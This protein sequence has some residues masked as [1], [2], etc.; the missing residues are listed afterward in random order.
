MVHVR[1]EFFDLA[2]G[3][4]AP[5]AE[6]ALRRIAALYAVET[7]VRGKPPDLRRAAR[8][9]RSRALVEDL[10]T[11]FEAQLLRLPGRAPTAKAIRYALNHRAGLE[12]LLDDGRIEADQV[13][14][15]TGPFHRPLVPPIAGQ[16]APEV[17]QA[18][19][20]GYRTPSDVP[21]G[22]VLVVL[23]PDEVPA[24]KSFRNLEGVAVMAAENAGVADIVGA[25]TLVASQA[26]VDALTARARPSKRQEASA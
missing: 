3:G 13:V 26:A 17:F 6:E 16:L 8:Q 22:T 24:A 2:K 25:A 20:A 21:A 11:W 7:E 14:V 1:R 19:S 9:A 12:R 10:F 5:I 18:H 4:T 23:G 15:A